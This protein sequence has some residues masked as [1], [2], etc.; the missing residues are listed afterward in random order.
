MRLLTYLTDLFPLPFL[1][2]HYQPISLPPRSRNLSY[3]HTALLSRSEISGAYMIIVLLLASTSASNM[4]KYYKLPLI[5]QSSTYC[6]Y[7][8]MQVIQSAYAFFTSFPF[9]SFSSSPPLWP[10]TIILLPPRGFESYIW[11][12]H[13]NLASFHERQVSTFFFFFFLQYMLHLLSAD[14]YSHT[15]VRGNREAGRIIVCH[16]LSIH[17]S[18]QRIKKRIKKKR[19]A[20][21]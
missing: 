21:E 8:Y 9:F 4:D 19:W 7:K 14:Y 12:C 1:Q 18:R 13:S 3:V 16:F 11:F 2:F 17:L 15:I 20:N 10:L 6:M 5:L